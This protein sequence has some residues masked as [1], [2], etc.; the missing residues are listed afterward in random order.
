MGPRAG[1]DLCEKSRPHGIRSPDR[2]APEFRKVFI[3]EFLMIEKIIK[4]GGGVT[5]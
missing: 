1:L 5:A 3:F 2:Q 4:G